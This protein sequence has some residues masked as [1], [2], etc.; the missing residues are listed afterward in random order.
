MG[1]NSIQ[2]FKT[3]SVGGGQDPVWPGQEK[4]QN[5]PVKRR[6]LEKG[7]RQSIFHFSA[8]LICIS[9]S[10]V[11]IFSLQNVKIDHCRPRRLPAGERPSPKPVAG[12]DTRS[13]GCYAR[14]L[15]PIS[16][17]VATMKVENHALLG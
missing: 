2:S 15:I 1:V 11:Q 5:P 13:E 4:T 10:S 9:K 16:N 14:V 17:R 8:V 6:Q 3:R 12:L 7:T